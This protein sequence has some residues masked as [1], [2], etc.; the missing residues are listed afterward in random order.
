MVSQSVLQ[1]ACKWKGFVATTLFHTPL[2]LTKYFHAMKKDTD[3]LTQQLQASLANTV[4]VRQLA[5]AKLVVSI[6][7]EPPRW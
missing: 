4:N 7:Q 2:T 1:N 5:V 3:K 6:I